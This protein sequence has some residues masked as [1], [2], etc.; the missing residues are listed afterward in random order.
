MYCQPLLSKCKQCGVNSDRKTIIR[1]PT[2]HDVLFGRGGS[3]NSHEGNILFRRVVNQY[4]D[5]YMAADKHCKP[6]IAN[7]VVSVIY[8]LNPP[9]RFLAPVHDSQKN[10]KKDGCVLWYNV[11]LN[12]ARA[13]ASQCLRERIRFDTKCKQSTSKEGGHYM[14][15]VSKSSSTFSCHSRS[16][17]STVLKN[18]ENDSPDVECKNL[19]QKRYICDR[20][21]TDSRIKG[22]SWQSNTFLHPPSE[23]SYTSFYYPTNY[24][25]HVKYPGEH[26]NGDKQIQPPHN[27]EEKEQ[28]I[29]CSS[30]IGSFF[31]VENNSLGPSMTFMSPF[32]PDGRMIQEVKG[33][34]KFPIVLPSS[35]STVSD[36]TYQ[37]DN[38]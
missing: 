10:Y 11:G 26:S 37:S 13:K 25:I 36:L 5:A 17:R 2:N 34:P 3:I 8:N 32:L 9:G 27:E 22:A 38:I 14:K 33:T 28:L 19:F 6:K 7:K 18:G 24:D 35:S 16:N 23:I 21:N 15:V 1:S 20:N 30:W 12:K 29:S 31:S 4:K